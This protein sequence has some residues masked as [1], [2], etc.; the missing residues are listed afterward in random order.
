M[1]SK[2]LLLY[3]N[4]NRGFERNEKIRFSADDY[5]HTISVRNAYGRIVG[6]YRCFKN[7]SAKTTFHDLYRTSTSYWVPGDRLN[8]GDILSI[9][10]RLVSDSYYCSFFADSRLNGE[11]YEEDTDYNFFGLVKYNDVTCVDRTEI[12]LCFNNL[13]DES[14]SFKD[15]DFSGLTSKTFRF[16]KDIEYDIINIPQYLAPAT[17]QIT[18]VTY[19]TV[20]FS[21]DTTSS[22]FYRGLTTSGVFRSNLQV[23][24]NVLI[25]FRQDGTKVVSTPQESFV[26]ASFGV[27]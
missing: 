23:S 25:R 24:N 14:Q 12:D 5:L 19:T 20:Q 15:F 26:G 2:N 4:F 9:R 11:T 22:T 10:Y 3:G 17:V 6:S 7:V 18:N 13:L 27:L 1:T 8:I 21:L 16:I